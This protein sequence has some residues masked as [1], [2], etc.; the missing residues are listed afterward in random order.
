VHTYELGGVPHEDSYCG[1]CGKNWP[2]AQST[3]DDRRDAG[4]THD[5]LESL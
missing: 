1:V 4:E 3:A 5:A 2:R